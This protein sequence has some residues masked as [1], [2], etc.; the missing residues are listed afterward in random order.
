MGDTRETKL[1]R[2][3]RFRRRVPA[4]TASALE[5]I[6]KTVEGDGIPE[7]YTRRAQA[8]A[9]R[10]IASSNTPYGPLIQTLTLDCPNR[11]TLEFPIA[12]PFAM[13][14]HCFYNCGAFRRLFVQMHNQRPS[15]AA[16][17]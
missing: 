7:L 16:A 17:P 11:Q 8:D 3:D 6:L 13:L 4:V 9:R 14:W 1:R 15:S 10:I 5:A 12:E 2:L